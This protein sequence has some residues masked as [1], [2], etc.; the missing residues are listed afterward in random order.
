MKKINRKS[1]YSVI[2][3]IV[4][5]ITTLIYKEYQ[6]PSTQNR[7]FGVTYMTMNNP[8]YEVINNELINA[9]SEKISE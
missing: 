3:L 2:I 8:F 5:L 4:A 7:V 6:S 1:V 9:P